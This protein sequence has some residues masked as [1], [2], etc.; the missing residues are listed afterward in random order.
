MGLLRRALNSISRDRQAG[1]AALYAL[2]LGASL[3]S[4]LALTAHAGSTLDWNP[5]ALASAFAVGA[6]YDLVTASYFSIPLVLYLALL[7]ERAFA[8]R[9]QRV[10]LRFGF[11]CAV[12]LLLF[13][14][15]IEWVFWSEFGARLNFIAVDYLVYTREV[16]GTITESWPLGWILFGFFVLALAAYRL[17]FRGRWVDTWLT[18]RT[19]TPRRLAVGTALLALPVL[20]GL[21]VTDNRVPEF[22]NHYNQELARNGVH[23][24]FAAF[25]ANELDYDRFYTTSDS[26]AAFKRVR[27]LLSTEGSRYVSSEPTDLRRLIDNPGEER[28]YNV[29]QIT[30]ESLSASF[31][32]LFGNPDGLTP[33]LDRLGTQGILFTDFRATGTR[34]VRGMEALVLSVPPTP[35]LSIVKRPHNEGLFTL[36]SVLRTR[37]YDTAFLYG[38]YGYFDNMNYFFAHNGYRVVDRA[39]M[40]RE[41]TTFAT[42]WG[43]CDEDLLRWSLEDADRSFA[44]GKP[45]FQFVMTTSNH[46]PYEYP[47]GRIDI[48]PGSRNGAVKYT[49]WAIGDFLRQAQSKPWFAD[50]IFVI[51]A[52]H[53]ASSAGAS[54]LPVKKYEIPL[55][56]YAP[57]LFEPRRVDVLASQIDYAPTLLG[58]MHWDYESRFYGRDVLA[59]GS[60][61]ARAL[62]AS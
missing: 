50:T 51:V 45:F 20:F 23:S 31:M 32:G 1:T 5:L 54:D 34:T 26:T 39:A 27:K 62:I 19:P 2:V 35:G 30:V 43:A 14:I 13:T 40:P 33:N 52:D 42:V 41:A 38:G 61:E 49:D 12:F 4:R 16:L 10:L 46:R 9:G 15:A 6:F 8:W 60:G 55:I 59:P 7:P 21:S 17:V 57:K 36:G 53:C 48:A 29:V 58:L 24:F 18:S 44:A 11:F 25:R 47:A 56:V 28:H 22:D 3:L 37:G